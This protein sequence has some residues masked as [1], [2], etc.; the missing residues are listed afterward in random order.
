MGLELQ[1]LAFLISILFHFFF[2]GRA[3]KVILFFL[4]PAGAPKSN[5]SFKN[6]FKKLHFQKDP[7]SGIPAGAP[8][9]NFFFKN[10]LEKLH[11]Q[12]DPGSGIPAG[13]PQS[14]IFFKNPFILN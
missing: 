10:P 9:K 5:F 8:K 2:F 7:G 4:I 13:A 3:P 14:K 6:H 1:G 12:R 11:F